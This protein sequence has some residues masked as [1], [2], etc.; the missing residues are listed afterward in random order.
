MSNKKSR[1]MY[2]DVDDTLIVWSNRYPYGVAAPMA[3]EFIK[4]AQKHFEIRWLTA[5][6]SSGQLSDN[7]A[8]VLSEYLL[9]KISPKELQLFN[10][11]KSWR[12]NKTEGIDFDDPRPWVWIEDNILVRE[13][14]YIGS[15]N[16]AHCHY[17]AN[18]SHNIVMLQK[19]WKLV[20]VDHNLSE[21]PSYPYSKIIKEPN[22]ALVEKYLKADLNILV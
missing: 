14:F 16:L 2:L 11:P 9:N 7:K 6:C 12:L 18:V 5:W 17:K 3:V 22:M 13:K 10:N 21:A 15:K 8:K 19:A 20:A 1:I 4:W